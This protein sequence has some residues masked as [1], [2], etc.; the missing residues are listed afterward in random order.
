[1]A[2]TPQ[3]NT[4]LA[5]IADVLRASDDVV[6]CGHVSPDGD[7]LGSQLALAAALRSLG[8]RVACLLAKDEPA[9][10]RLSFL[11]GFA[12]HAF[13]GAL[14]RCRRQGASY[15]A[16]RLEVHLWKS[17]LRLRPTS[18]SGCPLPSEFAPRRS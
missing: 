13:A 18:C 11:P 5:A 10:A 15:R 8:K 16:E 14:Q 6:I 7:C 9:D 17:A 2:P 3:T 4:D 12:P 1:M